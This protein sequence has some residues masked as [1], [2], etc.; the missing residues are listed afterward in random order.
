LKELWTATYREKFVPNAFVENF[1][2]SLARF[3]Q[4]EG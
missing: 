3:Q 2:M 1:F 4:A